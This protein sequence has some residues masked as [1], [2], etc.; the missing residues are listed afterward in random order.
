MPLRA[1]DPRVVDVPLEAFL[2][3]VT[4]IDPLDLPLGSSPDNQDIT[5]IPGGFDSRPGTHRIFPAGA[6]TTYTYGKSFFQ[7]NENPLNLYLD[8]AGVFWQ[9]DVVNS[10]GAKTNVHQVVAGLWAQSVSAFGREFI[11]FSDGLHGQDIPRQYDGTNFDRVTQDGPGAPPTSVAD[12]N[13]Q[14][15][16]STMAFQD[17]GS[18]SAISESGNVVT[19]TTAAPHGLTEVFGFVLI[20]GV[21]TSV[22]FNGL[23]QIDSI[24]S[25]TTFTVVNAGTGIASDTTGTVSL[26]TIVVTTAAPH[27]LSVGDAAIIS[28]NGGTLNNSQNQTSNTPSPAY[29]TV[30]KV[31]S[32]TVFWF[33]LTGPSGTLNTTSISVANNGN[34]QIGGMLSTGAHQLVQMFL[35]R[36]G[37]LTKPSPPL[38]WVCGGN[39][40]AQVTGVAIGPANIVARVLGLTGAGGSFFFTLENN[41]IIPGNSLLFNGGTPPAT[42]VQALVIPDNVTTTFTL[43]IPDN[44]LFAAE[45]IDQPGSNLFAQRVIGPCL[46]FTLYA[47]RLGVW[48][49]WNRVERFLNMGFEGGTVVANQPLGWGTFGAGGA[50]SAGA[51][52]FGLAWQITGDGSGNAKGALTQ[53]AYQNY[54]GN[55]IILPATQYS[56][57]LWAKAS[58]AGLN[59]NVQAVL[60]SVSAGF[61]ATAA[62]PIANVSTTG[63]FV[64]A[65]FSLATPAV[66]PADLILTIQETGLNN[67]ATITL[68]EVEIIFTNQPYLDTVAYFSYAEDPEAFDGVTGKIGAE[69]DQNP[70]RCFAQLRDQL[71]FGTSGGLHKTQDNAATEPS[72]WDIST[73]SHVVGPLSFRAMDPG[74]FGAG[75]TGEEWIAIAS[76]AGVY[77]YGGGPLWKVSQ[78]IQPTWDQMNFAAVQTLWLKNVPNKR[79][80]HIGVPQ[81]S[82]TAPSVQLVMDYRELDT[83]QQIA[84]A[85]GVR[86][87]QYSGKMLATDMARKWTRWSLQTNFGEILARPNGQLEF[88]VGAGNGVTPGQQNGN[89][90]VYFFDPAKLTDDDYGQIVPY[91]TSYFFVNHQ[92][93]QELQLGSYRKLFCYSAYYASGKGNLVVT[94]LAGALTNPYPA[95]LARQLALTQNNDIEIPLNVP[96]SRVAFKIAVNPLGGQTDVKLSVRKMIISIR[97]HPM[98]P[99]RGAA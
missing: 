2:G 63:S 89:G 69:D 93:E 91:W 73:I 55:P 20:R 76:Y 75:D 36:M 18:I 49:E 15:N 9:E 51:S 52:D 47:G 70:I 56:F 3:L 54:L 34:V 92:Q 35:T 6:T 59:G 40:Q 43:D 10:P 72:G 38:T 25:A 86:I 27:G 26:G 28:G 42:V 88:S 23:Y 1:A 65:V 16:I 85:P 98:S 99:L 81:G 90:N 97:K 24:P 74:K 66:I 58:G 82:A 32:P 17:V 61:T 46:G 33:A 21:V 95:S 19:V 11:A 68:D 4:E 41:A 30:V 53:T 8:S 80:I 50:L 67:G 13:T 5:F 96:G 22:G 71:V 39:K 48:G 77:L 78:E 12:I 62:I 87:S 64:S 45:P 37:Y 31:V 60:S 57:R 7:S 83:D 79:R 14:V 94:P 29:W 84:G 44:T